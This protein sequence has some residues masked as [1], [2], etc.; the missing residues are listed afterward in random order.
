MFNRTSKHVHISIANL[1]KL[2]KHLTMSTEHLHFLVNS[3][4]FNLRY[5]V[6]ILICKFTP[7]SSIYL[8]AKV[9]PPFFLLRCNC[10]CK[11]LN[12]ET[13]CGC[14]CLSVTSNIKVNEN[15]NNKMPQYNT[16]VLFFIS[17]KNISV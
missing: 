3:L 8:L 9:L 14:R 16:S 12:K 10:G 7:L 2:Q 5:K 11:L 1:C 15:Y 6:K 17:S 4:N 13:L